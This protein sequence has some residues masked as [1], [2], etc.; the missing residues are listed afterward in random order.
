M[1]DIKLLNYYRKKIGKLL[2]DRGKGDYF[3][4]RIPIAQEIRTR[5]EKWDCIKVKFM[6]IKR[7]KYQK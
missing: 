6:H 2:Q 5:I 7:N 3:L 4:I 1:Y